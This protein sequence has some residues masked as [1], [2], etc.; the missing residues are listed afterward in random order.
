M[1]GGRKGIK[2]PFERQSGKPGWTAQFQ[3]RGTVR[4]SNIQPERFFLLS[5]KKGLQF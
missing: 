5:I 1:A 2:R 4:L 3:A